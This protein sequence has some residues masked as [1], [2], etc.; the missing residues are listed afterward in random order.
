MLNR[1]F[2]EVAIVAR[3]KE[4]SGFQYQSAQLAAYFKIPTARMS[5]VLLKLVAE[6]QIRRVRCGGNPTVYYIPSA[7]QLAAEA[8]LAARGL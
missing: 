7:Q 6:K 1:E 3:L 5:E 2:S 8:A 4:R